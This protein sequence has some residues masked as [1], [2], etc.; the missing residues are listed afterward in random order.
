MQRRRITWLVIFAV[1]AVLV[2]VAA[3]LW[4]W[5]SWLLPSPRTS[6]PGQNYL[7][8]DLDIGP[9]GPVLLFVHRCVVELLMAVTL[10]RRK[11][12]F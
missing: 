1:I 12:R 3:L 8:A 9:L 2:V 11:R 5:W 10:Q 6:R 4:R 7:I